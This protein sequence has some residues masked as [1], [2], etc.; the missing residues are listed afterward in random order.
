MKLQLRGVAARHPASRPGTA[1]SLQP[2]DLD[3]E[4]GEQVAVI[5]AS[6][7]GKT[8]LL[9]VLALAMAPSAGSLALDGQVGGK[10]PAPPHEGGAQ[11]F[12]RPDELMAC[13]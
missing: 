13:R 9:Q 8:T 7:A 12:D 1:P 4:A 2:L 10:G 3:V 5:G 11:D 6:G